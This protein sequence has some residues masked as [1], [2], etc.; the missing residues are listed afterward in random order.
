MKIKEESSKT[1]LLKKLKKVPIL[2]GMANV[3][4]NFIGSTDYKNASPMMRDILV[5]HV[6]TDLTDKI[7]KIKSSTLLIWGTNDEA[8]PYEDGQELDSMIK[9][10]GLVTYEGCSHYAYLERLN[11]T[12]SVL[13]S[14][15]S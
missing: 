3:A 6:N 12:I 4:K 10:S 7:S 14:F 2:N 9:D 8:V 1:K 5:R 15:L 13:K 11:Q